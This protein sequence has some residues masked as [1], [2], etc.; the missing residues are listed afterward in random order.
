MEAAMATCFLL[1]LTY[2]LDLVVTFRFQVGVTF[3]LFV[4]LTERM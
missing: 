1:I 4:G 3:A 2:S